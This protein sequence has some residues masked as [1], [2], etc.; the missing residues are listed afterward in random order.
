MTQRSKSKAVNHSKAT[1]K[2]VIDRGVS[3]KIPPNPPFSKGGMVSTIAALATPPGSGGVGIIRVSGPLALDIA[4]HITQLALKPRYATWTP[5]YA[6]NNTELDEGIAL[7]FKAP[8]SFTGEDV[9]ELQAHG[10][11]VVL[12]QLLARA[13]ELGAVMAEPGEF[14]KRAF[15]NN[16]IDL[17]QAE[18]VADL[19]QAHSSSAAQAAMRSLQGDF[20]K[21]I[22]ALI[23]QLTDLRIM[24]EAALDFPEEEIDFLSEWPIL[25]QLQTLQHEIQ[26]LICASTQGAVLREGIHLVIVGEPNVGKSSLMNDLAGYDA[27]IVTPIAGTTRDVLRETILLDGL[28]V[29]LVDT[30]GLRHTDDIIEQQGITRALNEVDK[31]E[32]VL[33]LIDA[34]KTPLQDIT[35][36]DTIWPSM[37]QPCPAP[38]KIIL[39]RNKVDLTGEVAG[40]QTCALGPVLQISAQTGEG[41]SALIHHLKQLVLPPA[42]E[43]IFMGRRRH[44]DALQLAQQRINQGITQLQEYHAA[45]LL[46]EELRLAQESLGTITGQVTSDDLLGKIFSTFCIGK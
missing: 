24:I 23:Q 2:I 15:L 14:S 21:R 11:V 20:S 27:A 12:D 10:G 31:A 1:G 34:T 26:A 45:E 3:G 9:L 42:T 41:I 37:T 39:V 33:L 16:K 25:Q 4:K 35:H 40:M 30:A 19:I 18:A 22:H 44:L 8:H 28:P 29:R 38:E 17:L 36:W 5:F 7:Y 32:Y 43:G 6:N 46:A 13:L